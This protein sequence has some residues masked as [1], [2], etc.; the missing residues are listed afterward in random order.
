MRSSL[1][2]KSTAHLTL[3]MMLALLIS[4]GVALAQNDEIVAPSA[5]SAQPT[6][7]ML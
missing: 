1:R 6:C 4:G 5:P 7:V 3:A 2:V